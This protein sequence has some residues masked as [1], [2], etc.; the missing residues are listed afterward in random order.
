MTNTRKLGSGSKHCSDLRTPGFYARKKSDGGVAFV[1]D[2]EVVESKYLVVYG[3][4]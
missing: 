4:V 1:P 2:T 3:S